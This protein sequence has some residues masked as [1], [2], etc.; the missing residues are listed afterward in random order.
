MRRICI[1][2]SRLYSLMCL[3]VD[4]SESKGQ[5]LNFLILYKLKNY[6]RKNIMNVLFLN[7]QKPLEKRIYTNNF[8]TFL[9]LGVGWSLVQE[10]SSVILH[11]YFKKRK[12]T[13]EI[14]HSASTGNLFYSFHIYSTLF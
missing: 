14:L 12:N 6:K 10:S 2:T 1:L 9:H 11:Q 4:I 8:M 7:G 5:I 13:V 3:L